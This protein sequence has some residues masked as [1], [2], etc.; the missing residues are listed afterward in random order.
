M[1]VIKRDREAI[2]AYLRE[3]D[4]DPNEIL[5]E[6][7]SDRGYY[8]RSHLSSDHKYF[9]PWPEGFDWGYF[10]GLLVPISP[11]GYPREWTRDD[12]REVVIEVLEEIELAKARKRAER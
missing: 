9:Y 7:V 2:Q 8:M 5:E 6:G 3:F 12:I 11:R 4:L 10:D 1:G